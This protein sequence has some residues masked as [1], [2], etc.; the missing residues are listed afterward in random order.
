ME[1][2]KRLVV[3]N[4]LGWQGVGWMNKACRGLLGQTISYGATMVDTCDYSLIKTHR[5]YN[6]E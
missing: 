3:E 4:T 1:T 6:S 2:I 5:M